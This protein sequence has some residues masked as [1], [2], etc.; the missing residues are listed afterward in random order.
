LNVILRRC[1]SVGVQPRLIASSAAGLDEAVV[2]TGCVNRIVGTTADGRAIVSFK[3][4]EATYD[5]VTLALRGFHQVDNAA[6][7]ILIAEALREKD[8][9]ISHEAIVQ[10]IENATHP[11]RLE[12][13][14]GSPQFLFDGAHNPAAAIA[15][16]NYLDEF[17]DDPIVM[18]FGAMRD[19]ALP[20]M[21]RALFPKVARVILTTVDNPRAASIEELIAAVPEG[22]GQLD[23]LR[24][25]NVSEALELAREI[26]PPNG[27]VCV[28]GSL[29]LIGA[30]Q[31]QLRAGLRKD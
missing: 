29:H 9:R 31:E 30:A 25:S 13:W 19:K 14:P 20:E 2:S 28:T 15:L 7:A 22:L 1:D 17:L 16:R 8:F 4:H 18:V 10:G 21:M 11:G 12:M 3:T 5:R 24:A 23:I 6:T 27:V 26:T